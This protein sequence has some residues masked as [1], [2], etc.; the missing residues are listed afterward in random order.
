MKLADILCIETVVLPL[1]NSIKEK[2]I[3]EL[4]QA[5]AKSG[6][7]A[8]YQKV[9]E[10]VFAREAVM[11]TGVG[12]GVAIPH[13]K[14]DAAPD[15]VAA[16]GV[17]KTPIDF[18]AIDGKPVNL[19]WLIVGPPGQTG[20]HLKAL[21]RISRLMHLEDFRNTLITAKTPAHAMEAIIAQE[22]ESFSNISQS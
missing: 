22:E 19:I 12:D 21:S 14:S 8:D 20:P 4:V 11:S 2:L 17:S 6:K 10:A 3:E 5:I 18:E 16:L 15:I 1:K 13:G 9:L 7:L